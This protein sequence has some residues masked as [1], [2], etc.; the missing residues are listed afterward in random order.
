MKSAVKRRKS[1]F[2]KKTKAEI[3]I[4]SIVEVLFVLY[5]LSLIVPFLW[6]FVSSF[7]YFVDFQLDMAGGKPFSF[8]SKWQWSNY[9]DAFKMMQYAVDVI[10]EEKR[11]DGYESLITPFFSHIDEATYDKILSWVEQGGVWVVGP[12]S[13]VFDDALLRFSHA[14][15]G[16]LEEVGGVYLKYNIPVSHKD[17]KATYENGEPVSVRSYFD[18]YELQG[19]TSLATY[20]E[21]DLKN[22]HVVTEK[23]Y[24]KG[25]I[26][27]VGS[28]LSGAE[29]A[30][31]AGIQPLARCS[32]NLS[33]D[34]YKGENKGI[35]CI[36]V[37]GKEGVIEL[38]GVYENKLDG[39]CYEG[40]IVVPPYGVYVFI[41]K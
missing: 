14:P 37:D 5:A 38:D 35:C 7:K 40:K 27:V 3:V 8:P 39:K 41:K 22:L 15:F 16:R 23:P 10:G 31:L 32:E 12:M 21:G 25:K 28:I 33:L 20:S 2:S 34:A 36:E 9:I 4:Y 26:V 18:G 24:G 13:D 6:M 1:L 19:A 30:R 17:Y 29:Y 11:L